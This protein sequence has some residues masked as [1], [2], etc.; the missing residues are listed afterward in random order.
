M[1]WPLGAPQIYAAPPR[2]LKLRPGHDNEE[3]EEKKNKDAATIQD[4]MVSRSGHLLATI[5]QTTMSIWQTSV[6]NQNK[7]MS[8]SD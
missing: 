4:F 6:R 8:G 2:E 3:K 5:T 7:S 1:Y